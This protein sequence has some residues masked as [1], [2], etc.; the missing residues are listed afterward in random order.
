MQVC[1]YMYIF[2]ELNLTACVTICTY[3][4]FSNVLKQQVAI[5]SSFEKL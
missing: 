3:N 1:V 5:H 4:E 2:N